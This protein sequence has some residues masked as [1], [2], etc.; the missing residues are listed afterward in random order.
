MYS[1]NTQFTYF[2]YARDCKRLLVNITWL[3]LQLVSD[4]QVKGI[5]FTDF[6]MEQFIEYMGVNKS[7]F[8]GSYF[9]NPLQNT[10]EKI[11]SLTSVSTL[12]APSCLILLKNEKL[13]NI[14]LIYNIM[15]ATLTDENYQQEK[16]FDLDFDLGGIPLQSLAIIYCVPV[17]NF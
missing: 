4:L 2:K 11:F 9:I 1:I 15:P 12:P 7:H 3:K 16:I 8:P 5:P 10:G 13:S 6:E 14:D 17:R